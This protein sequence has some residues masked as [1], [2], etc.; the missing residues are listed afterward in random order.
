MQWFKAD[1]HIHTVL[2]P[3]GGLDMSPVSIIKQAVLKGLDFI[4]ITDHNS[5]RHCRLAQEIGR[6]HGITV[7]AGAE[8]NT[9][10]EIH[11]LTFFEDMD[12][13]SK[14][15][16]Y[17]DENLMFIENKPEIFGYQLIVDEDEN[18]LEEEVRMLGAAMNTS[19]DEISEAVAALDGIFIPAHINRLHNSVYSQLGFLPPSAHIDAVEVSPVA[20]YMKFLE[21]HPETGRFCHVNNSDS[22]H[23]ERI[24]LVTTEYYME[25]PDFNEFRMA[26][27]NENGRKVRSI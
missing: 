14:F 15:Q 8:V 2:S 24:G 23:I 1:L 20:D 7:L 11:C 4:A 9:K 3:C 27:R 25:K 22:H 12:K 17:I 5:T 19:I 6:K 26:I 16:Q 18:I 10:E 21:E 13:A